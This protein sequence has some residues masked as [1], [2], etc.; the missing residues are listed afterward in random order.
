MELGL[1][2]RM[3]SLL[4]SLVKPLTFGSQT[5]SQVPFEE[6]LRFPK[7]FVCHFRDPVHQQC[8]GPVPTLFQMKLRQNVS[9]IVGNMKEV[10]LRRGA[11]SGFEILRRSTIFIDRCCELH[12]RRLVNVSA[13]QNCSARARPSKL[14]SL[15]WISEIC[16]KVFSLINR[17]LD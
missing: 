17:L 11:T 14:P 8:I 16:R 9:P 13:Q 1:G 12:E 15:M 10:H 3:T 7:D 2:E 6:H 4:P 5:I